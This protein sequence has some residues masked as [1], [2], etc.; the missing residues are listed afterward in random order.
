MR[1]IWLSGDP[2]FDMPAVDT[3]SPENIHS[4]VMGGE[5]SE[6]VGIKLRLRSSGIRHSVVG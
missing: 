1:P 6:N 2:Q 4:S 3:L 5:W